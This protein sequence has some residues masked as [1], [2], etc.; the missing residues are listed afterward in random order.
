MPT[1]VVNVRTT[2]WEV[3][4]G[5]NSGIEVR[6]GT[7]VLPNGYFGNPY[8]LKDESQRDAVLARYKA[9]F[10]RRI[11]TDRVFRERILKL[12]GRVLGC[13][14]KPLACHGDV[15]VQFLDWVKTEPGQLWL[16]G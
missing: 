4:I 8:K 14:C 16:A 2:G 6:I 10:W 13:H 7:E 15:I 12:E 1:T 5:R 9:W 11:N 3:Y